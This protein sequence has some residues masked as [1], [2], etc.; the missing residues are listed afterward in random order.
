[1]R[2]KIKISIKSLFFP[3]AIIFIA[4]SF[5][6]AYFSSTT[7]VTGNSFSI[8]EVEHQCQNFPGPEFCPAGVENITIIGT[9]ENGCPIY[10][11]TSVGQ[12]RIVINEVY[13]DV[14]ALHGTI[15]DEWI[16]IYNAGD[17]A[18][19]IKDW[20]LEDNGGFADRET[21]NQNYIIDPGQFVLLSSNASI[22]NQYWNLVPESAIKIALGG[23]RIFSGLSNDG[24]K[25]ILKNSDGI[26]ID[27]I[28][29]GDDASVFISP[30]PDVQKGHSISRILAGFDTDLAIDFTD[31][32]L[33]TPGS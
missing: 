30:I 23:S 13:Y 32:I 3:L 31:L 11:C 14:D 1:M 2:E 9:D 19:N 26:S 5:T 33:P 28:S 29:Y 18:V 24:D 20:Y 16:E 25:I 6:G 22:W 12:G 8:S 7:S 17:A 10:S 4:T 21:I 15:A 27:Q